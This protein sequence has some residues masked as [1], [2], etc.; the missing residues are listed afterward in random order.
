[1]RFRDYPF[2]YYICSCYF[3]VRSGGIYSKRSAIEQFKVWQ[4]L[5][6]TSVSRRV[7]VLFI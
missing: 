6:N 3:S 5:I 1:M 7:I 2:E 4:I